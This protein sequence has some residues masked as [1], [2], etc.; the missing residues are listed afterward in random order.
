MNDDNPYAVSDLCIGGADAAA[1]IVDG[2]GFLVDGDRIVCGA[3]VVLPPVC[4]FTGATEDLTP[5]TVMT[6][7]PSFRIVV[8]QRQCHM[9]WWIAR[10]EQRRRRI[11]SL[12]CFAAGVVAVL[13]FLAGLTMQ[14]PVSAMMVLSGFV[15]FFGSIVALIRFTWTPVVDR[16]RSPNTYWIRGLPADYLT[17]ITS[18]AQPWPTSGDDR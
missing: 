10:G 1:D 16:F 17:R 9:T 5:V 4:L 2:T 6:Q 3:R 8:V 18:W 7:F 12:A 14:P 15:L 11:K 13:L